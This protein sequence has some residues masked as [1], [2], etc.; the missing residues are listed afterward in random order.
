MDDIVADYKKQRIP[1]LEEE[2]REEVI[3]SL[4]ENP[5]VI[6]KARYIALLDIRR[7]KKIDENVEFK[8]PDPPSRSDF[9]SF[10]NKVRKI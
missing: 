5:E 8:A 6:E 2:L 1:E 9:L 10:F 4:S 3:Q 7:Q